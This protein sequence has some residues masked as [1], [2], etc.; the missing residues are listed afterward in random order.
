MRFIFLISFFLSLE[1][2]SLRAQSID[3]KPISEN[4]NFHTLDNSLG[5]NSNNVFA[6]TQDRNGYIWIGTEKGLQRYDGLRFMDGFTEKSKIGSLMVYS[7]FPDESHHRILYDQPDNILRKW[8]YWTHNSKELGPGGTHFSSEVPCQDWNQ[9]AWF[10]KE[11]WIDPRS[12]QNEPKGLA[13]VQKKGSPVYRHVYFINDRPRGKIWIVDSANG[14][15]LFNKK[16]PLTTKNSTESFNPSVLGKLKQ[17]APT[18]HKIASDRHGNLWFLSWSRMFY[19][20][21]RKKETLTTY[22]LSWILK[23]EKNISTLPT[24]VSDILEDD[25]GILW[26]TTAK[27]GLLRYDFKKN[28]FSYILRHPGNPIS[29]QYNHQINAIFQDREENIW[30]GT[31]QGISI[32]NPYHP[33][34]STIN[35]QNESKLSGNISEISTVSLIHQREIWVGTWGSGISIYDTSF[36]FKKKLFFNG[37]TNENQVWSLLQQEDGTIWAGCQSGGLN[38]IGPK[39]DLIKT[40]YPVE[41]GGSTIKCMIHDNLG[42]TLLG[43]HN[44][45]I[46]VYVKR[47]ARFRPFNLLGLP[48]NS[49][50]S[51]IESLFLGHNG[52]CWLGVWNGLAEFNIQKNV[53]K[54]IYQPFPGINIRCWGINR[55]NDS[56]LMVG[57]E[58]YGTYFFNEHKK[59]FR[60]ILINEIQSHGSVFALDKDIQGQIWFSTDFGIGH[61]D[62]GSQR[63]FLYR[64]DK[65][66]INSSF[67][68]CNFLHL[69]GGKW[70]TWTSAEILFF[71]PY[72]IK[73]LERIQDSVVI[74]GFRVF[75]KP[76]FIDSLVQLH[77]PI[78]L[79]YK[80]N[81]LE[82]EFSNLQFSENQKAKFY[83][84]LIGIDSNWVFGGTRG[85]AS[86]TG[87][88]PG[89]YTFKVKSENGVNI[90][91]NT[92]ILIQIS[93]PFWANFWF[94]TLVV[95]TILSLFYLL[96]RWYILRQKKEASFKEQIAKTE[97]MVLRAQMNPHFIFNCINSIDALILS[98]EK[99]LATAYLNK[100][101][102][103]IRSILDSS[104]QNTIS[105]ASDIETLKLYIDMEL[106]RNENKFSAE[107]H[108]DESL[109]NEDLQVPPLIIQPYVENSI[110]HGLRNREEPGGKLLIYI[111]NEDPYIVFIIEDNGVG[112]SATINPS[113]HRSYGMKMSSDRVNFFNREHHIPVII[114]D[115]YQ[116]GIPAGT[117]VQV[118]L[119]K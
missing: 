80:E 25:H 90:T 52:T 84:Q 49:T 94:K 28:N 27:A 3:S 86:Y 83:Y 92:L 71:L 48:P 20:L 118:T 7:L 29:L 108:I 105:L 116:E 13:W 53:F 4:F 119:K 10:F 1:L 89:N 79:H 22:S 68:G 61:Y 43:L 87:L 111:R 64:P 102:R 37:K 114:N 50:L 106:F 41:I 11:Y 5:L 66:L 34:F 103:L 85:F 104:K 21:D 17:I 58:S 72:S 51:P 39:G 117:R 18:I 110:L 96:F 88:S 101:A 99:Y 91:G 100:F 19:R 97:M 35:I 26:L 15:Y 46:V 55:Y 78:Q 16:N 42:N 93:A 36:H 76:L 98:N 95:L 62:P 73:S 2:N 67:Q 113:H 107:I 57:T 32:F 8:D 69:K 56:L 6:L 82:I 60:K 77:K 47:E 14:L 63:S 112:R 70:L 9:K 59:T 45:K 12:I 40:I 65:G 54:K 109:W 23:Q 38:I 44:G 75:S 30:L 33:Y 81:F 24:W 115:L 31:D 74:T